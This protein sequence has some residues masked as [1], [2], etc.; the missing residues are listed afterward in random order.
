MSRFEINMEGR[1]H[2]ISGYNYGCRCEECRSAKAIK[3]KEYE[4]TE[5]SIRRR[6][7]HQKMK[8]NPEYMEKVRA[9]DRARVYNP[10]K[11]RWQMLH[12]KYGITKVMFEQMMEEQNGVCAI[13]KNPPNRNYLAVDHD[14]S[15][16]PGAR[17]CGECVRGLLC[18]SCNSVLGRLND[19]A[20]NLIE[21]LNKH[22]KDR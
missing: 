18:A 6:S 10:E 2:G 8:S 21:Y 13:C 4:S 19:D 9:R 22:T 5:A 7:Y 12:K 14:H 11:S 20:T 16:C 1:K 3:R 15:C 17:T